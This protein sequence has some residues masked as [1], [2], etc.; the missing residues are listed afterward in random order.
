MRT[1]CLGECSQIWVYMMFPND[2]IQ[3]TPSQPIV[4]ESEGH[5]AW[6]G[7]AISLKPG[8]RGGIRTPPAPIL[9]RKRSLG[10]LSGPGKWCQQFLRGASAKPG[11]DLGWGLGK[12]PE[13]G[14]DVSA[15]VLKV[16]RHPD[17]WP[18]L[19]LALRA[20]G[21]SS[22]TIISGGM[23]YS[24]ILPESQAVSHE[25]GRGSLRPP[26]LLGISRI[27][28]G[29]KGL[30]PIDK[31]TTTSIY[32]TTCPTTSEKLIFSKRI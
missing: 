1:S 22:R 2:K 31:C 14:L 12:R 8:A 20:F 18:F 27:S 26:Q 11:S 16:P 32:L 30:Q 10:E 9:R 28:G 23:F 24:S 6:G 29:H 21:N 25:I 7:L 17:H 3:V 5:F 15:V 19:A 13:R 4:T